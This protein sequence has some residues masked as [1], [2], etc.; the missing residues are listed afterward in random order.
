[1]KLTKNRLKEI[2]KEEIQKLNEANLDAM[3]GQFGFDKIDQD[4]GVF[5]FVNNKAKLNAWS[6]GKKA[7][8]GRMNGK[9]NKI[10]KDSQGKQLADYLRKKFKLK[11]A[12]D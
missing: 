7:S 5:F 11:N 6:D 2:I 9:D 12:F 3:L 10:F 8:V 1:M 4:G